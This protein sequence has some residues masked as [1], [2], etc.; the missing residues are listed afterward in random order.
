MDTS[1]LQI[2]K[3]NIVKHLHHERFPNSVR[4]PKNMQFRSKVARKSYTCHLL[5][6]NRGQSI[7]WYQYRLRAEGIESIPRYWWMKGWL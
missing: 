2:S 5:V 1:Q 7:P 3:R 4:A 6:K